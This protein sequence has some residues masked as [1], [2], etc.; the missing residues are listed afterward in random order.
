M[1][2]L[3]S[4]LK[5]RS[6]ILKN[7]IALSPMCQYAS[8]DG[9]PGDWQ[10]MHLGARAAGGAGLVMT[11][12]TA[13]VPEGRI[14]P[15]DAGLW[16][17]SQIGSWQRIISF[18]KSQGSVAGIQLA[19]AGRKASADYPWRGGKSLSETDGGWE[20]K[21]PTAE[22]FGLHL[23]KV[24]KEM[25]ISEIEQLVEEFGR[26]TKRVLQ[27]GAEV[28]EIHAGHGYIIHEFLSPLTNKRADL[29][30]GSF[31]NRIRILLEIVRAVRNEWPEHLPLFVR[32]STTDWDEK[33]WSIEDSVRLSHMLKA[34]GVDVIDSSSGFVAPSAT[35]YPVKPLW[36]VE[37]SS[38]NR[39][40]VNISTGA[41]GFITNPHDA[42]QVIDENKA[43]IILLGREFLRQP[44]WPMLA[45]K[46]LGVDVLNTGSVRIAHW[47][48]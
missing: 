40:E 8:I 39:R 32:L 14:S 46:E 20:T 15:W 38:T 43:D 1:S 12:A 28:V 2:S 48:I 16:E 31:E 27:T 30:G 45:A 18:I 41:V 24:P 6:I 33:G 26:A 34:M 9:H 37:L 22:A 21:A 36:Q 25:S 29:Y 19:H 11:E 35:P 47:I 10:L 7:R 4:P 3:F 44:H 23:S 13:V 17:D 42:Q 5:L